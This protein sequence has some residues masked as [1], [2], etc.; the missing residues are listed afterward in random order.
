M[1]TETD[2]GKLGSSE[3]RNSSRIV[4]IL[5]KI[6]C[7]HCFFIVVVIVVID[8]IFNYCKYLTKQL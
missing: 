7:Y 4:K 6:L 1:T 5:L 8:P 3:M 2:F